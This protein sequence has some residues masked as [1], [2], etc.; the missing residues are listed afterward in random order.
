MAKLKLAHLQSM[1]PLPI[2]LIIC[3]APT[4]RSDFATFVMTHDPLYSRRGRAIKAAH[5]FSP[6]IPAMTSL[7]PT[8]F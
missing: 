6:A 3:L 7:L 2:S 5:M 1:G 4:H 8:D